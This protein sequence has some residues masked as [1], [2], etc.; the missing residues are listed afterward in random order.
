[1]KFT[2]LEDMDPQASLTIFQILL[3]IE[4]HKKEYGELL[5]D[6]TFALCE[7]AGSIDKVRIIF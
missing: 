1:M 7:K 6:I 4:E 2:Q 5:N 3:Y